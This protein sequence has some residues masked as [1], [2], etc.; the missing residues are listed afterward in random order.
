MPILRLRQVEIEK[1]MCVL[2]LNDFPEPES[3][4]ES[5][6]LRKVC[7]PFT[8]LCA[9][10]DRA[11]ASHGQLSCGKRSMTLP[12]SVPVSC[13]LSLSNRSYWGIQT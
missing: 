13:P 2:L 6:F 10:K 7:A 1:L 5:V 8:S 9:I 12:V 4:F 3:E 11:D